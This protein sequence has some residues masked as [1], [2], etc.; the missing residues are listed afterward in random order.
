MSSNSDRLGQWALG[1]GPSTSGSTLAPNLI[2][3]IDHMRDSRLNKVSTHPLLR[4]RPRKTRRGKPTTSW[5]NR[6]PGMFLPAR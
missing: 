4:F 3:G 1:Q 6:T 5:K 2:R